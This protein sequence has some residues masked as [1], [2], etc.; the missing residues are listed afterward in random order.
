VAPHEYQLEASSLSRE[1]LK[2]L[3]QHLEI[4][5]K[6]LTVLSPDAIPPSRGCWPED[7]RET[8]VYHEWI[9]IPTPISYE[10]IRE[11]RRQNSQDDETLVY[12]TLPMGMYMRRDVKRQTYITIVVNFIGEDR[13]AYI[14]RIDDFLGSDARGAAEGRDLFGFA[15]FMLVHLK[16]LASRWEQVLNNIDGSLSFD[17]S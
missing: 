17:V 7:R 6:F 8:D 16:A 1:S 3:V 13:Q 4:P 10:F 15:A 2:Q 11:Q 9:I 14:T 12:N 5:D